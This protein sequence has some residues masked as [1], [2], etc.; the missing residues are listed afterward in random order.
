MY[1]WAGAQLGIVGK[2]TDGAGNRVLTRE[3]SELVHGYRL[4]R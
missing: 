2:Y 3:L 1:L 4:L